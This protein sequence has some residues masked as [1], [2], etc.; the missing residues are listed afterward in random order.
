M[1]ACTPKLD[2]GCEGW[3]I[4]T[5]VCESLRHGAR[6]QVEKGDE[7]EAATTFQCETL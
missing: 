5:H 2:A 3:G 1:S 7:V 6:G 4:H